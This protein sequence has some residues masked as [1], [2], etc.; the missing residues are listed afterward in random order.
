MSLKKI[1]PFLLGLVAATIAAVLVVGTIAYGQL[2]I[3]KTKYEAEFLNTGELATGNEVRVA[4]M[5]VGQVTSVGLEGD[6]VLVQ[7]RLD[8]AVDLG[9]ATRAQ[10][11]LATL[12]GTRYLELDPDGAG[13]V[14]DHR[15]PLSHT[16]VPYNLQ[17][18]LQNGTPLFDQIDA[19]TLRKSLAASADTLRGKGP[20]ISAALD[21]LSRL[22]GVVLKRKDEVSE[23]IQNLDSVS[24]LV[25]QRSDQLFGLMTQ[26]NTLL[27]E[28]LHRRDTIENLLHDA[29]T[30]T[31][32]LNDLLR[33]DGPQVRPLLDN[34]RQLTDVL[35]QQDD[36]VNRA[37]SVIGSSGRYVANAT[38]NG[39]YANV[40]LP[41]SLIP[42]NLLCGLHVI[43]GC[44]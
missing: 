34:A 6:H 24:N 21:G 8:K 40:Y 22:S 13:S 12:L 36:A 33:E 43:T 15:I 14:P 18:V 9:A 4:G 25:D 28:V 10:I 30:L 2:G 27:R 1:N 5:R 29:A 32:Q 16:S 44:K 38:G 20:E 23:L 11:K 7:F 37:L 35:H 41:Y 17:D 42:D 26:S 31:D 39:P 19:D 3:G